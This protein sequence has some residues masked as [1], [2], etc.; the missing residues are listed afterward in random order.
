MKRTA[1]LS[2]I[3]LFLGMQISFAQKSQQLDYNLRKALE[4]LDNKDEKGAMKYINQQIE[5]SPKSA[6][7]YVLRARVYQEQEKYG[8]AL[9]DINQAISLWKKNGAFEKYT[10]YWWRADIYCDMEMYDKALADFDRVCKDVLKKG[11]KDLI[12][13][14]LYQ[15]AQVHYELK[16]YTQA[17]ADYNLMLKHNE[18]DQVAMIGLVRNMMAR[19]D[20]DGAISMANQC[21][22]Y[23]AD[24]SEIYRFRMQAYDKKG[25]TDKAIDDAV[26][27]FEFSDNPSSELMNPIF[28][29]HLSY[30][31]AL[32]NSKINSDSENSRSWK[33]LRITLYELGYDYVNAI[34]GYNALEEEFGAS[35]SI[36]Y[37]RSQC[38]H[39]IGDSERAIADITKSIEM[40]NGKDYYALAERADFYRESG[41][42]ENAINDFSR[43]IELAPMSA[44]AYYKRG[45]CYELNGDDNNA[46]K[47]Y[48]SGIDVDKE[49]PYI[50]LMR[51]ELHRKRGDEKLAVADFEEVLRQDT[52]AESGSCRQYALLFL[53]RNDEAIEWMDKIVAS[54]PENNGVYYDKACLFARMGR[55]DDSIIALKLSLE[56][57]YRSFAHIEHDDDMDAIRNH[58]DFIAMIEEYKAMPI[59]T[60]AGGTSKDSD[61][62]AV[63]SEIQMKKMYSGVYEVPCTINNL[64][65]KFI[66]DTGA[67]TVSISSVEASFMLKNG[68]LKEDDIKGKE[69]YSVATGEIHEGTTIRLR[70]IKIGDAVLRNVDASVAHNQQAPLLLGQ[71]VLERFGTITI[72]NINSKLI[73]K[74]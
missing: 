47:D 53:N 72:D 42:Y 11:D 3:L 13:E 64:P 70:E 24:Y 73:I 16:D 68:Y 21:K 23:D 31:L 59:Q 54:D 69:Y 41:Q 30:A 71:S 25:N 49:Y 57:G 45:W 9:T 51:G 43:M 12:H 20:Y 44:Y 1:L 48:N 60:V 63:I 38:Y 5:E 29:K 28:K 15:R 66:F 67:S 4:L 17:D 58:P 50:F 36:Y 74:Q 19:E 7:A 33:M 27:Y 37:Y 40:G 10:L 55:I 39:E 35:R 6:D 56:K 8:Q 65:L 34:A 26:K 14:A 32:I 61:E 52:V 22:K 18:A 62:I 46:M 2:I